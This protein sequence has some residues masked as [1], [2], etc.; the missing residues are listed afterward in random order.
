MNIWNLLESYLKRHHG[1]NLPEIRYFDGNDSYSDQY[2]NF[3]AKTLEESVKLF[4]REQNE[5]RN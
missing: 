3:K 1:E 2:G 4:L 5:R